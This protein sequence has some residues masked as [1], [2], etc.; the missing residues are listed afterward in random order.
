[1]TLPVSTSGLNPGRGLPN[2]TSGERDATQPH[3]R[4]QTEPSFPNSGEAGR[5]ESYGN[6]CGLAR[7]VELIGEQWSLLVVRDLLLEPKAFD[8]LR[9]TLPTIAADDLRTRLDGLVASGVLR[10]S[11]GDLFELTRFGRDLEPVVLALSSWGARALGDP[12]PGDIF[13][14]D[15]AF[16][17]LR[18]TFQPERAR[19]V[20]AG[21]EVWFGPMVVSVRVDD[22]QLTVEEGE[23]PGADLVVS[24]P[25]LKHLMAAELTPTDA[26]WLGLAETKGNPRLLNTFVQLFHIA[27]APEIPALAA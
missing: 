23:L 10:R 4:D 17:A 20:R 11:G 21:F 7:A 19:G 22:G 26:L 12:E 16:L 13:T 14:L 24:S 18:A 9:T 15:M 2:R 8:Q 3:S 6:F 1:M 25:V 5:S 27:A